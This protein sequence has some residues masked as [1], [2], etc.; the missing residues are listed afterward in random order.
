MVLFCACMYMVVLDSFRRVS[1]SGLYAWKLLLDQTGQVRRLPCGLLVSAR[2][3][4][5]EE[6][7]VEEELGKVKGQREGTVVNVVWQKSNQLYLE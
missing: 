4:M 2:G 3:W 1:L 5:W 7:R 6:A